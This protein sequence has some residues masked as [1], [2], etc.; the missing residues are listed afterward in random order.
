M[1]SKHL[2]FKAMREDLR[3]RSWM[4]ALSV[5]GSLLTLPV[6]WLL[7]INNVSGMRPGFLSS[8]AERA[9]YFLGIALDFWRTTANYLG[10][11]FVIAGALVAAL[12]GF[13]FIFH[14]NQVDTW[15]SLP[16][17][18]G[19]LFWVCYVN[20]C[21]VWLLPMLTGTV[22]AAALSGGMVLGAAGGSMRYLYEVVKAAAVT[23]GVWTV[24][25]LLVYHLVLVAMMFSGN[26]LNT[27]VSMLV[28]GFGSISLYTLIVLTCEYYLDT[29]YY[30]GD[31]GIMGAVYGSPFFSAVLLMMEWGEEAEGCSIW[32]NLLIVA[33]L[34]ACAWALYRRRPSELAEQGIRNGILTAVLRVGTTLGAGVSG[35]MFFCAL[36]GD[37]ILWSIFGAVLAAVLVHGVLDVVFRM[38]F[39]AFFAHRLQMA[40]TV[41]AALL[42]CLAIRGDWL[43]YDSYLPEKEQIE[44]IGVQT[45]ALTNRTAW[46]EVFSLNSMEYRDVDTIYAFLQKMAEAPVYGGERKTDI[47]VRLSFKNG[48]TIYRRYFVGKEDREQLMPLISSGEYM[49]YAYCLSETVA[50]DCEV[51]LEPVMGTWGTWGRWDFRERKFARGELLELFRAYNQDVLE[52]PETVLFGEGRLLTEVMLSYRRRDGYRAE[53]TLHIYESM[54]RTLEALRALGYESQTVLRKAEEVASVN[55]ILGIGEWGENAT[56]ETLVE[57]AR[58]KYG[59]DT[60]EQ[61]VVDTEAYGGTVFM[62]TENVPQA[63][64]DG[65]SRE[66]VLYITEPEEIEELLSLISYSREHKGEGVFKKPVISISMTDRKGESA[67]CYIKK[68]ELPEKYILRFGELIEELAAE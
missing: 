55:L 41:A 16:I 5:L 15:H 17:K 47:M 53:I 58:K 46:E 38:E 4:L 44:E 26:V 10:G 39:R 57:A 1:T 48:R 12:A 62:E 24:V 59:E 28:M 42:L 64:Y 65:E 54:E 66:L 67:S 23:F 18:R 49:K 61:S 13:R 40:G 2:F 19:T 45:Y 22:L 34:A 63:V 51:T 68:G 8:T 30:F 50:Q 21:L 32:I 3:H 52:R 20:G 37:E 27:M 9:D 31:R 43:G 6:T 25:F 14:K 29:W 35:W 11:M 36:T 7:V 33:A 56:A 60:G